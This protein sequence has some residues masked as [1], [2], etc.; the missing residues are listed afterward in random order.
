MNMNLT[1]KIMVEKLKSLEG[2]SKDIIDNNVIRNIC[3]G[4]I[5]NCNDEII[6]NDNIKK[7]FIDFAE[8]YGISANKYTIKTVSNNYEHSYIMLID[9]QDY[10]RIQKIF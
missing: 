6:K 1:E 3:I 4:N 2:W 7:D 8:K 9:E 5:K 10:N